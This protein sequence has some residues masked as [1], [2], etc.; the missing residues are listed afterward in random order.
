MDDVH[1]TRIGA[2]TLEHRALGRAIR[3]ARAR[4]GLSQESAAFRAGIHRNQWGA[5]ERGEANPTFTSLLRVGTALRLALSEVMGLYERQI[6]DTLVM[7]A[8]R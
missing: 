6:A 1:A 8:A 5:L 2:R 4:R 7:R 3:E